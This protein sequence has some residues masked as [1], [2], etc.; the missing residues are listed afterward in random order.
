MVTDPGHPPRSAAATGTAV[1]TGTTPQDASFP[2]PGLPGLDPAWS[3][4][5]IATDADGLERT[6][7]VLDSAANGANGAA[8]TAATGSAGTI[9]CVHGNPTWSYA[10]R[11]VLADPPPGWRV[12]APD[13]LDMGYS[14]RTGTHRPLARRIDDL[15]RLTAA[16]GV[17][18]GPVVLLAHDWGGPIA[19]G[20]AL[21]H[22]EQLA[23][24]VLTNTAVHQPEDSSAPRLIRAARLPGVLDNVTVRTATF[25]RGTTGL[26]RPAL[27]PR[28][29]A[30]YAA[31]YD[32]PARRRAVGG[33]V[34]DIPL[35]PDHP[36]AATLDA[37]AAGLSELTEVPA[38]LLWGPEDPVFS[39]RYLHDLEARL[40]QA[41]VHRVEGASHLTPE[42]ADLAGALRRWL[43]V[44]VEG[45]DATAADA[46]LDPGRA[47]SQPNPRLQTRILPLNPGE[48]RMI[49]TSLR[50]SLVSVAEPAVP[51]WRLYID[52]EEYPNLLARVDGYFLA[53][54]LPSGRRDVRLVYDP[55]SQRLGLYL[56]LLTLGLAAFAGGRRVAGFLPGRGGGW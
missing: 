6:W 47:R 34:R 35:D 41:D 49:T 30:A 5:V 24:L 45:Q 23:G 13:H 22:R 33:F 18:D 31:P 43:P 7:H 50:R 12:V 3:R 19:L 53:F 28:T 55:A 52:E 42:D 25:V 56:T 17:D 44:R 27:D 38:L 51:G 39:D 15:V 9:L 8:G 20:W 54:L 29:R 32:T 48:T 46:E 1:A 11:S 36:S 4:L 16:M 40:P 10:F 14:Q 37:I 26:A 21:A 2:P